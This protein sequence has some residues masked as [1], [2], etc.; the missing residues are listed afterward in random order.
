M[1]N[2]QNPSIEVVPLDRTHADLYQLI[3][4]I[5]PM[6]SFHLFLAIPAVITGIKKLLRYTK[7]LMNGKSDR[8]NRKLNLQIVGAILAILKG[9]AQLFDNLGDRDEEE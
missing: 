3:N 7:K 4:D 9:I 6:Q 2:E 5:D 8:I 1:K